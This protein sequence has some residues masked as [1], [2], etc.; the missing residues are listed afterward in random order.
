MKRKFINVLTLTGALVLG[1]GFLASCDNNT[2]VVKKEITGM[3][4]ANKDELTAEWKKGDADRIIKLNFVGDSVN[5]GQAISDG[6]LK[7]VSSDQAV[8]AAN[9]VYVQAAGAGEATI[10]VTYTNTEELGGK[11]LTDSFTVKVEKSAA[12]EKA[13]EATIK[14]FKEVE[15]E[16]DDNKNLVN[17]QIYKVTGKIKGFGK[18]SSS[19]SNKSSDASVYG[20]LFLED[21]DG[22]ELQIYGS[23]VT[24]TVLKFEDGKWTFTNPQDFTSNSW[25]SGLNKGDEVTMLLTRCDYYGTIEGNGLFVNGPTRIAPTEMSLKDIINYVSPT[26]QLRLYKSTGTIKGFGTSEK[27]LSEDIKNA[28][29]YGNFFIEDDAGN[30]IYVY[31][32][33]ADTNAIKYNNSGLWKLSNP[34]NF[35]TNEV[36]STL[37]VG[38]KISFICNRL[39][40]NE[41]QEIQMDN[42][43]KVVE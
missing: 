21:N 34:Q 9:G 13:I 40:Y 11:S 32:A 12:E 42:V 20:N 18:N 30:S 5:P 25:T 15:I 4:I 26:E 6:L 41:T 28:T 3:T 22:E 39:S 36:T 33:T 23:S 24:N 8:V 7:I 10:T 37:K 16:T 27:S 14:E 19:L 29:A 43:V 17:K 31:G 35:L 38:D 2:P 1:A